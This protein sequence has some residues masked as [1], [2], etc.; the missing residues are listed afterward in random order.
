MLLAV[1]GRLLFAGGRDLNHDGCVSTAD[2]EA[3][4]QMV[5]AESPQ[6]NTE[7]DFDGNGKV[8]LRDALRFGQWLN[9]LW[10][11]R[12]VNCAAV[13][14]PNPSDE[15]VY[16]KYQANLAARKPAWTG[17]NVRAQYP[18][19]T[20]VTAPAYSYDRVC[21]VAEAESLFGDPAYTDEVLSKGVSIYGKRVY[22]NYHA[23]LDAIHTA[24]LPVIVTT[25]VV[26]NT[27]YRSY[28]AILQSL[29][30]GSISESL[31]RVLVRSL[32][33]CARVYGQEEAAQSIRDY[34]TAALCLLDATVRAYLSAVEGRTPEF[35]SLFG[36]SKYVDF[37]Q[38]EPRGHYVESEK[39]MRYF[40]TMMWLSRSDLALEIGGCGSTLEMKKGAMILWDC[41]V[42]S[43]AYPEWQKVNGLIEYMVGM[44]DGLSP[45][46][47]G[48]LMSDL[49]IA[50]V[51]KELNSFDQAAFDSALSAGNYGLQM[52]MSDF[53][54]FHGLVMDTL[55]LPAVFSFM[56][57]RF[58]LDAF[59]HSQTLYPLTKRQLPSSLDI[60]FVLGDNSALGD[61]ADIDAVT[62]V[63]GILG[64][65]RELYDDLSEGT[66]HSTMY[67]SWLDF[68]RTLNGAQNNGKLSPAF[69][70]QTWRQKM[71]NTQLASWAQLRSNTILYVKQAA[72]GGS[73]HHPTASVEPYP[74]FFAGVA[75]YA[76]QG[77]NLFKPI[78]PDIA[79]FFGTVAE[80][81]I[82]VSVDG[83]PGLYV[84]KVYDGW[85][86]D[87]IYE[88]EQ[89]SPFDPDAEEMTMREFDNMVPAEGI[90][91][92][93]P[94]IERS[95][96]SIADVVT[97]P[98][99]NTGPARVLHAATGFVN[100]MS[101]VVQMDTSAVW[102]VGPVTPYY[103]VTTSGSS[104]NRIDA[105]QWR[106]ALLSCSSQPSHE[107]YLVPTWRT[108]VDGGSPLVKRPA[109][110]EDVFFDEGSGK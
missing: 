15:T 21:Y 36:R 2:V 12:S 1:C 32:D 83:L 58:V 77:A 59:T 29:E 46:S 89:H 43:G 69:R 10:Y 104:P 22:A 82:V 14:L 25:D 66:W 76:R 34:F 74:E 60:A 28:D 108:A 56:P 27:V 57:Q 106:E 52:I 90:G 86:F 73:C 84:T 3:L 17:A 72:T 109:W 4:L 105:D 87:L 45:A 67:S 79:V 48:L 92:F 81:K 38:F 49:G 23:A 68:L 75:E 97:K 42:N 110:A 37:S 91:D 88:S 64:S 44:S 70:T 99:D 71:R 94:F 41:V 35:I 19:G 9:G 103:D 53:R 102:F 39:L 51:P 63:A 26:L 100:L 62:G 78:E 20:F 8:N 65:Q 61:D 16:E 55:P 50:D 40:Q 30:E 101:V 24:D 33:Y 47:M 95:Y 11:D 7:L 93:D 13:R 80:K 5:T 107:K 31:R 85:Y 98:A 54:D 96:A 6:N 18:A